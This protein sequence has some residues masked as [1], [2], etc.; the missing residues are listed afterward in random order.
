MSGI[1]V[2]TQSPISTTA[3]KPSGTTPYN[4]SNEAS[5]TTGPASVEATTTALPT[6]TYPPAQPGSR[7]PAPTGTA[8]QY[9]PLQPTPTTSSADAGPPAPQPGAFPTLAS[10]APLPPPPRAGEKYE[11]PIAPQSSAMP[12]Y[13]PPQMNIPVPTQAIGSHQQP[14]ST[15]TAPSSSYP[16]NL[17][18]DT[19]DN[20]RRSL[21]HPPGY[22]QNTYASEMSA[23][24]RRASEAQQNS[25]NYGIPPGQGGGTGGF[26]EQSVWDTAKSWASQAG[27][28]LS[29]VEAEVWKKINK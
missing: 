27:E 17:P 28:K 10:K 14:T 6:S 11:P 12:S 25:S 4:P 26:E 3:A 1:P 29:A 5:R 22:Q 15:S 9:A 23:D 16:V 19:S 21:D 20:A 24:Q 18:S 13:M 8:N 2:Y 7:P